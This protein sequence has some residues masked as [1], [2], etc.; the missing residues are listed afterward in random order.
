LV[1]D[2]HL[3]LITKNIFKAINV[4]WEI[5][6][7]NKKRH[8]R[9]GV[10]GGCWGLFVAQAFL[11]EGLALIAFFAGGVGITGFHL[12]L[13]GGRLGGKHGATQGQDQTGNEQF[14]HFQFLGSRMTVGAAW[15]L[16]T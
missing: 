3:E 5:L 8:H 11:H 2:H 12:A 10:G 16:A 4:P 13:L 1:R 14:F 9:D 6:D 7:A 15:L